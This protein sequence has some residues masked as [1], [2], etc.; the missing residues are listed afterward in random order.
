MRH[1]H[2]MKNEIEKHTKW[3]RLFPL[4]F[5][6]KSNPS[7]LS[8]PVANTC[9]TLG[10]QPIYSSTF[11]PHDRRTQERLEW[12]FPP[13]SHDTYPSIPLGFEFVPSSLILDRRQQVQWIINRFFVSYPWID[14]ESSPKDIGFEVHVKATQK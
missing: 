2:K 4:Q 8:I 14:A 1:Q 13:W 11:T 6:T 7:T 3:N 9:W 5:H 10:L 12:D